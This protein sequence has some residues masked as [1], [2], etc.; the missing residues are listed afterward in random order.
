M[1]CPSDPTTVAY[2]EKIAE[3]ERALA[4]TS[5]AL[6]AAINKITAHERALGSIKATATRGLRH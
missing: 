5:A 3:L 2:Q 1:T 4:D 6:S